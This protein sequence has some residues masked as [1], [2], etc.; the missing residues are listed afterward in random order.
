[1]PSARGCVPITRDIRRPRHHERAAKIDD[2]AVKKRKLSSLVGLLEK[3]RPRRVR[4]ATRHARGRPPRPFVVVRDGLRVRQARRRVLRGEGQQAHARATEG[5]STRRDGTRPFPPRPAAR[6]PTA[7]HFIDARRVLRAPRPR[8]ATHL[9]L[10]PLARAATPRAPTVSRPRRD[11]RAI[12]QRALPGQAPRAGW[13]QVPRA[14]HVRSRRGRQVRRLLLRRHRRRPRH[15]RRQILRRARRSNLSRVRRRIRAMRASLPPSR[16]QARGGVTQT[17]PLGRLRRRR[18]GG[19]R[20]GV[21]PR[22]SHRNG[23]G[24]RHQHGRR[25]RHPGARQQGTGGASKRAVSSRSFSRH[26]RFP[27]SSAYL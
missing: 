7:A 27:F 3:T 22:A 12:R 1:M 26:P 17:S 24:S 11:P 18:Q 16:R 19:V 20:R 4:R 15:R 14:P 13:R 21:H 2:R 6:V 5:T 23:G 8:D 9:T 25:R 10:T